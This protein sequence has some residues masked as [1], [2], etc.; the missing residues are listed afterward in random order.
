[1]MAPTHMLLTWIIVACV[2]NII[3]YNK[4][5]CLYPRATLEDRISLICTG[6]SDTTIYRTFR[7]YL[8]RGWTISL[9]STDLPLPTLRSLSI[10]RPRSIEGPSSWVIPLLHYPAPAFSFNNRSAM[11][12]T[13]PVSASSWTLLVDDARRCRMHYELIRDPQLY[14][15]YV[16]DSNEIL[17]DPLFY[18]ME[19]SSSA[20]PRL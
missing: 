13:D 17:R 4:A 5:Y 6:R 11:L 12:R 14:Y 16:R 2:M 18:S 9:C 20:H 8:Q 19:S 15:T 1:M 3:T 7:K 10:N